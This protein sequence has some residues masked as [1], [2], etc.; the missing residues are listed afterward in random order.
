MII[1]QTEDMELV[2][3]IMLADGVWEYISTPEQEKET[4]EPVPSWQYILGSVDG[5]P[6]GLGIIHEINGGHNKC[7]VQVLPGHR[8]EYGMKFGLE[9]MQFIWDNNTFDYMVASISSRFPNVRKYA[10]AMGFKVVKTDE[11]CYK[12]DNVT[13]DTWL[14]VANRG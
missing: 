14:L 13:Y 5:E 9:G 11:K 6:V 7:H 2:K 1:E 12:L 8:K 3:K 4:F 10:E